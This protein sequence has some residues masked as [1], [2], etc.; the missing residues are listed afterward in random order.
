MPIT[1][2]S[3]DE[4]KISRMFVFRNATDTAPTAELVICSGKANFDFGGNTTQVPLKD[5]VRFAIPDLTVAEGA[6]LETTTMVCMSGLEAVS[7]STPPV[8]FQIMNWTIESAQSVQDGTQVVVDVNLAIFAL[9][10]Q[11]A[12]I[13]RGV[14][15][16]VTILLRKD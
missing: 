1:P 12:L 5:E 14:A 9:P 11:N 10:P 6:V 3:F 8:A 16:H 7:T 15:Y 2:F 4:P 13:I